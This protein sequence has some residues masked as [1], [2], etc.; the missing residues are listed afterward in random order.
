MP[1]PPWAEE[2]GRGE[3]GEGEGEGPCCASCRSASAAA[4][5]VWVVTRTAEHETVVLGVRGSQ[6][7]A[8]ALV[9]DDIAS[10]G[11]PKVTIVRYVVASHAIP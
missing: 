10:R 6:E 2:L 9:E 3:R 8:A 4:F 5:I 1:A 11:F 7:D